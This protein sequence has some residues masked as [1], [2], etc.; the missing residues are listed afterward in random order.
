MIKYTYVATTYTPDAVT[1]RYVQALPKG[2]K[3]RAICKYPDWAKFKVFETATGKFGPGTGY[4]LREYL[5]DG[6]EI[7]ED[8]IDRVLKSRST[9]KWQ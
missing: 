5:T 1:G 6:E 2:E 8:V 3:L 9:E 7:P 4:T